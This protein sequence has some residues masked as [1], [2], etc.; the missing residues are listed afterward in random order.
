MSA[1]R[2]FYDNDCP[3]E[4]LAGKTIVFVG[5]GNQGRAQALNL[6]DTFKNQSALTPPQV[7]IANRKDTYAEKAAADGMTYKHDFADASSKA[8]VLFLLVPDEVITLKKWTK[9]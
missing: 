1:A 7:I 4:P 3:L 5:Y 2:R 8:D 9:I 6:M